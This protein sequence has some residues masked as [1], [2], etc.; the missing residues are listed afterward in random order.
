MNKITNYDELDIAVRGFTIS[1]IILTS[2][3]IDVFT[4]IGDKPK[5]A[6]ELADQNEWDLR[7]TTILL[8]ALCAMGLLDK[9]NG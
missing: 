1:R 8:D 9:K 7:G 4:K 6:K 5:S 2:V 3:Y